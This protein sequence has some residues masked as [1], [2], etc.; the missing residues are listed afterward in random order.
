M[1]DKVAQILGMIQDNDTMQ[2]E[3]LKAR[4][5]KKKFATTKSV[6]SAPPPPA[7]SSGFVQSAGSAMKGLFA[8][9]S[10]PAAPGCSRRSFLSC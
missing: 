3:R 8:S 1:R 9:S 2:Q 7:P 5:L 6:G 10:K 4:R